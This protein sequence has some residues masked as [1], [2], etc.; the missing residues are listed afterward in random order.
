[1]RRT[2]LL[3]ST[4]F[5]LLLFSTI[6]AQNTYQITVKVPNSPNSEIYLG[7]H[8]GENL[9]VNDTTQLNANGEGTFTG[10]KLPGGMY[11][12]YLT[13]TKNYFDIILSDNQKFTVKTDTSDFVNEMQI[14]GS[15]EN[16]VFY[17]Y[18]QF[19][20]ER[21]LKGMELNEELQ[22]ARQAND[23]EKV[24][25][26]QK[27]LQDLNEEV[28]AFRDEIIEKH[29]D[30]FFSKFLTMTKEI[31][32]P[33]PPE[34]ADQSYSYYYYRQ[35]YFD[36]IDFAD[37]RLLRTPV[38]EGKLKNY[39]SEVV[40]QIPDTLI[41]EVDVLIE[42]SRADSTM[43]RFVLG[44]L[45]NHFITSQIMGMDAVSIHIIKN[46]YL[47]EAHWSSEEYL[48]KMREKLEKEE[49]LL[50]GK[51]VQD[52]RMLSVPADYFKKV[53]DDASYEAPITT[54]QYVNLFDIK[55]DYTILMFW[56]ADCSHCQ[57]ALPE[58]QKVYNR[59]KDHGLEVVSFHMLMNEEGR[60]K[61]TKFINENQ[62]YDWYNVWDPT[63]HSR[64]KDKYNIASSPVL[65]LLDEDKIIRGKRIP[66]SIAE[67]LIIE[68]QLKDL[69]EGLEN[70]DAAKMQKI[71]DYWAS[72]T[73]EKSKEIVAK[74]AGRF[75][76]DEGQ[77]NEFK[78]FV[79]ANK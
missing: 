34:G 29:P 47:P 65:F 46:Y 49:P 15:P 70:D 41:K 8:F 58:L 72:F 14:T 77:A 5:L 60:E 71:K 9:Y 17:D 13:S 38:F 57:K 56:E 25:K 24:E 53:A 63:Y 74:I 40:P 28:F 68:M 32:V 2:K 52:L 43:F 23:K 19:F 54:G 10:E 66:P 78:A 3:I 20:Q 26:L 39:I 6:Q 51:Q 67:E 21:R 27:D 76:K 59:M 79:E 7:H 31:E 36:N 75:F 35:H 45:H 33:D 44:T 18:Q 61:W 1:M 48:D 16:K 12:I 22:A 64:F 73:D 30:M 55:A 11:F 42:K 4:V 62:M 69:T 50:Q 37:A